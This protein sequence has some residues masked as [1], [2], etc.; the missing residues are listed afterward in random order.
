MQRHDMAA[1]IPP[2]RHVLIAGPTASGKSALA[3]QIAQDQGGLIVNAD[4]LQVWSC[5]RVISARPSLHEEALAPHR[6]YGH[7]APGTP[8]SVGAWLSEVQALLSTGARLIVVGGTGLYL[9]A[10]SQG[11]AVIPPVP[12][13]IR[14]EAD[15]RMAQPDGLAQ[16]AAQLDDATARRIDLRNPARVQRAWEVLQS[17]GRGITAWQAETPPPL[18]GADSATRLVLTSDR[19]WLADRIA[20]R[21]HLMMDQGALDEVRA[22]LPVWDPVA[23][24]ARAIGAPELIGYLRHETTLPEAIDRA[25]I[26]SRQYAK[27]Q[28][29]FFR[30][31]LRD[32]TQLRVDGAA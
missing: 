21:F 17:T 25:I 10:L 29:I 13:H 7:L 11:L 5:W 9:H 19:D 20:R 27:S 31:R 22:M 8:Y 16:M 26:A 1:T 24:W 14:A 6:L 30:G 32:W 12:A 2:D 15:A 3:L 18:I 28:R 23:L 4:A